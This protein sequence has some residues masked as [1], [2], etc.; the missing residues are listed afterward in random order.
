MRTIKERIAQKEIV[1]GK[2]YRVLIKQD[3]KLFPINGDTISYR[4]FFISDVVYDGDEPLVF[5]EYITGDKKGS[6]AW[7]K[8]EQLD[9][10]EVLR[11]IDVTYKS[12]NN[13]NGGILDNDECIIFS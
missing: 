9:K 10:A 12:F 3:V 4:E 6:N 8:A 2:L 7:I 5:L 13:D 1:P 11:F